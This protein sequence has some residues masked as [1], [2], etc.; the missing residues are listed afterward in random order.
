MDENQTDASLLAIEEAQADIRMYE[1]Y[2][3]LVENENFVEVIMMGYLQN[4]AMNLFQELINGEYSNKDQME[5]HMRKIEAIGGL[6][7]YIEGLRER[8]ETAKVR[9]E[10]EREF[11]ARK[12]DEE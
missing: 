6:T 9:I 12:E 2:K 3:K 8:A 10:R 5:Q 11:M 1:K 7:D 4:H